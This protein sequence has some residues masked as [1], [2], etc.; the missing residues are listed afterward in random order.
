ME[1][2]GMEDNGESVVIILSK[3]SLEASPIKTTGLQKL[4]K[5]YEEIRGQIECFG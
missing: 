3:S 5:T 1:N 4:I 2:F